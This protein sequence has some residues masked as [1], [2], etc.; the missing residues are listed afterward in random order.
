[1]P[2]YLKAAKDFGPDALPLPLEHG[3]D[4]SRNLKALKV[5]ATLM[6]LGKAGLSAKIARNN[7]L[8]RRLAAAVEAAPDLELM[9][10]PQLSI[11]CFRYRPEGLAEEALDQLNEAVNERINGSGEFFFTPTRLAGRFTQ[12]ASI[13]HFATTEEDV[14]LLVERVR[15]VGAEAARSSV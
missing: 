7:A 10:A 12:R 9:A 5:W 3:F 6:H 15:E 14:D 1:M 2:P 13:L 8:A 11:V 4:L